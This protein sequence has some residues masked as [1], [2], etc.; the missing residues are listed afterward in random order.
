MQ[1]ASCLLS[2]G[3]I[4]GTSTKLHILCYK[5]HLTELDI[6]N[7]SPSVTTE[8]QLTSKNYN[9]KVTNKQSKRDIRSYVPT[10]ISFSGYARNL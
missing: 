9:F 1:L 8:Q 10:N 4:C 5:E 2:S 7:V 6:N 3:S